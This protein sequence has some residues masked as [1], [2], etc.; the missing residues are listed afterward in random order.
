MSN[1]QKLQYNEAANGHA[2]SSTT[3]TIQGEQNIRPGKDDDFLAGN[4]AVMLS[5]SPAENIAKTVILLPYKRTILT[6]SPN[7]HHQS[8]I[9]FHERHFF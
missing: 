7:H 3:P 6:R 9:K 8:K 4:A 2:N 1:L 5:L